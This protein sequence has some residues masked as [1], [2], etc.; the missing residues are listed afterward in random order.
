MTEYR[1]SCI[2]CG[3]EIIRQASDHKVYC[4]VCYGN[5]QKVVRDLK[6]T[7]PLPDNHCCEICG[8]A[9]SDIPVIYRNGS[10]ITPW[11]LDH[12]HSTESFR[13]YL[14]NSCNVGLG[15]FKDDPALLQ[16]AVDYLL[17]HKQKTA[18]Q[19]DA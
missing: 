2:S 3:V 12:C 18:M 13:G 1:S 7:N 4:D 17:A 14:C 8:R 15:K 11:R 19:D 6:K 16:K 9:E 10:P 5:S